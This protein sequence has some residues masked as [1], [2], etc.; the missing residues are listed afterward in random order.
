MNL[1]DMSF[2]I[3]GRQCDIL[4]VV[5]INHI[6]YVIFTDYSLDENNNFIE[7]Y[8]KVSKRNEDYELEVITDENLINMIKNN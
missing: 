7:Y 6:N 2:E 8:G 1:D 4:K 5:P 3:D